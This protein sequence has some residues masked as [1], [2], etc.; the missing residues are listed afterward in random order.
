LRLGLGVGLTIKHRRNYC[1]DPPSQ[2]HGDPHRVVAAVKKKRREEKRGEEKRR[3]K[4]RV[5]EKRREEKRREGKGREEKRREEKRREEKR[6]EEKRREEKRKCFLFAA[7]PK[8]FFL[9]GLKKLEQRSHKCV[10]LRVNM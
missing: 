9:D 4:K 5:E 6:R 8:A 7:Q 1:Y 3:E 2:N 10:E